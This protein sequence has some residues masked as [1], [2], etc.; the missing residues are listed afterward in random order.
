MILLRNYVYV[1]SSRNFMSVKYYIQINVI[2]IM[3]YLQS[4]LCFESCIH[5]LMLLE[6][7]P[8]VNLDL[9]S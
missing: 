4:Y 5:K 9:S 6:N 2:N 1:N 7:E 3:S 8:N